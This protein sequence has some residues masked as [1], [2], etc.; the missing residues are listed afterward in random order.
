MIWPAVLSNLA[1]WPPP[2][3]FTCSW[4]P[5]YH[6]SGSVPELDYAPRMWLLICTELIIMSHHSLKTGKHRCLPVNTTKAM[7]RKIRRHAAR[8]HVSGRHTCS[9]RFEPAAMRELIFEFFSFLASPF[10]SF[11]HMSFKKKKIALDIWKRQMCIW[12]H[13]KIHR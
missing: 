5:L 12:Q 4:R 9:P 2:R 8:M 6:F 3:N 10:D 7:E 11:G 1:I 13:Q